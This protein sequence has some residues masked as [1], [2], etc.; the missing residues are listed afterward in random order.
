MT[1]AQPFLAISIQ[2]DLSIILQE[3]AHLQVQLYYVPCAL[4]AQV[5]LSNQ[6]PCMQAGTSPAEVGY[7]E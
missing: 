3:E 1:L 2:S 6:S 5:L 7:A 4:R